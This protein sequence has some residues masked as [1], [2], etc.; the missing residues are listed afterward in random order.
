MK[1]KLRPYVLESWFSIKLFRKNFHDGWEREGAAIAV[2]HKG[3]LVVD[4]QG[5][6]ADASALRKWTPQ[7]RTIVFSA[8][9][10]SFAN[11]YI[12]GYSMSVKWWSTH[13]KVI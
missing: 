3:E 12:K 7:T 2:Y 4:L 11:N 6:Y 8:T 10:V 5:G 13:R 1:G 9:K